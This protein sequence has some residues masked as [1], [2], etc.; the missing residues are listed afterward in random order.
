MRFLLFQIY[1]PLVSWGE[2]AVGGERQSSRHPSKSAIIGLVAAA[3]GIKREEEE[4]LDSL[5]NNLGVAVQLYSGGSVLKD[6]HTVQVPRSKSKI[7][8]H[9]RREELLGLDE[10]DN[11]IISRREYRCD[12]LSVVAV[13][14]KEEK[15][16]ITLEQIEGALHE[17]YFHLYFGRKSCVPSLP[18][19]PIII[20][21]SN[22][23]EVFDSY[24]VEF[25]LPIS[26]N[27][28]EWLQ[29]VFLAYPQKTLFESSVSYFWEDGI[30]S[31]LDLLQSV[32]RYDQPLS[33][34]RWQFTSRTEYM[35]VEKRL[36]VVDVPQ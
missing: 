1:A 11:A 33:R 35:A 31:G 36:E 7:V 29:D 5:S 15:T 34:R 10:K 30:E 17:P 20:D 6:F 12:S 24:R 23:K 3:L 21:K 28:P 16:E 26:E 25:P 18:L 13:Y 27:N 22:L 9:T 4:R 2:I 8:Y 19:A 14:L 32:E